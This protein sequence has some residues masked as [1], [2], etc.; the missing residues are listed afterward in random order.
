MSHGTLNGKVTKSRFTMNLS[1]RVLLQA[2]RSNNACGLCVAMTNC[3]N[4][5]GHDETR[6]C[7]HTCM[8]TYLFV[9]CDGH[10]QIPRYPYT[11]A[12]HRYPYTFAAWHDA[13][14]GEHLFNTLQHTVTHCNS[15]QHTATHC[16][17]VQHSATQ[18]NTV[19]QTATHFN[20]LHHTEQC[21][22]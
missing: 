3:E 5:L 13:M 16:S 6:L 17:T 18:C 4:H 7:M 22:A 9:M 8:H 2:V 14:P 20:T 10:D 12:G 1:C 19:Q 11:F 21:V 15:L